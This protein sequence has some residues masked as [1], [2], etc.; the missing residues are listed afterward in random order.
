MIEQL[1][2]EEMTV[3]EPNKF[4][5]SRE[6]TK[7]SLAERATRLFEERRNKQGVD[8]RLKNVEKENSD[9]KCLEIPF[10]DKSLVVTEVLP[11]RDFECFVL[12][13]K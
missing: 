2:D 13:N 7:P 9:T 1:L 6:I 10:Y 3:D 12:L 8:E 5:A 11:C 4:E